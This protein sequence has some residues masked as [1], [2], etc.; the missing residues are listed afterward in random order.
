MW[1]AALL[2]CTTSDVFSCEIST[3]PDNLYLTEEACLEEVALGVAYFRRA[4]V[5]VSGGCVKV[6]SIA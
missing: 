5:F 3:Q 1:L 2:V 6:G 4:S